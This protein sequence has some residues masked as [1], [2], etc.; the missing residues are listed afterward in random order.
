[1]IFKFKN[2]IF[3]AQITLNINNEIIHKVLHAKFL[4]VVIIDE[5]VTWKTHINSVIKQIFK[6]TG[7]YNNKNT[8]LHKLKYIKATLICIG[9]S[10][11]LT[12]GNLAL[13]Y[14]QQEFK[15]YFICRKD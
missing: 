8:A 6:S 7:I 2:K 5:N 9:L 4:G 13:A 11:Y 10:I 12:Y 1:M 3:E 15:T 14:T